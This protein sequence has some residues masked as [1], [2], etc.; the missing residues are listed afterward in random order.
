LTKQEELEEEATDSTLVYKN[1]L[2]EMND[3][4]AL[5]QTALRSKIAKFKTLK[6]KLHNSNMFVLEDR[7]GGY[8][9]VLTALKE[10]AA[11]AQAYN[12]ETP[13]HSKAALFLEDNVRRRGCGHYFQTFV[14][15]LRSIRGDR[16]GSGWKDRIQGAACSPE[17]E[18]SN[19]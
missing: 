11:K 2:S 14:Y 1:T 13:T 6:G 15:S 7:I 18:G 4:K 8:L 19:R 16:P 12:L 17:G 9:N 3:M 10:F 5:T